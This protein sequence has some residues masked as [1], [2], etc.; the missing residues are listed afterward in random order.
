MF[1]ADPKEVGHIFFLDDVPLAEGAAFFL[2]GNDFGDVV[3]QDHAHG[4]LNRYGG[5][6]IMRIHRGIGGVKV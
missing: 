1:L 3:A 5:H 4:V 2:A 6:Q